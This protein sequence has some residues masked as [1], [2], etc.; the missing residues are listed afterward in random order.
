MMSRPKPDF[1]VKK[2]A[3]VAGG[4]GFIGSAIARM[5]LERGASV[6]VVDS[7]SKDCGGSPGNL[8]ELRGRIT[9]IRGDAARSLPALKALKKADIIFNC[10]GMTNH[11]KSNAE[12]EKDMGYNALSHLALLELCAKYNPAARIVYLGSRGQYGAAGKKPVHESAPMHPLDFHSAHKTLGE[13]YHALYHRN[14]GIRAVMLR[15]TNVY[16]PRQDMRGG[17][18]GILNY[19]VKTCLNGGEIVIFGGRNRTKDF[20]FVED[21]ANAAL[22]AGAAGNAAGKVFN[23]GGNRVNLAEA[24]RKTIGITGRGTLR[25]KPFPDKLKKI[26]TGDVLLDSSAARRQLGWRPSTGLVSGLRKTVDFY[27]AGR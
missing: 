8:K 13:F 6:T 24:A 22:L 19:F 1:Y 26:D 21:A 25:V 9:F 14:R 16:G 18:P 3:L 5:L 20:I 11:L 15:I 7:L 23:V 12:P 17:N 4:A 10:I 2:K 27:K